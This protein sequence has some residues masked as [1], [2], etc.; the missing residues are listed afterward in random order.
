MSLNLTTVLA[1][2]ELLNE[3]YCVIECKQ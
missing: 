1:N 3:N 2:I